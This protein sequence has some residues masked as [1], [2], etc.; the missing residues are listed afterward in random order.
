MDFSTHQLAELACK[1][2]GGAAT[3]EDIMSTWHGIGKVIKVQLA[4]K[5]GVR[6]TGLGTFI[7]TS[8]ELIRNHVVV[9][10]SC[11]RRNAVCCSLMSVNNRYIYTH[12]LSSVFLKASQHS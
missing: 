11:A 7:L 4:Q 3:I 5:K 2:L 9:T 1:A 10:S 12:T 8:G 6:I